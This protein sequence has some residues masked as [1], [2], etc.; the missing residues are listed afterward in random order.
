[1]ALRCF[2]SFHSFIKSDQTKVCGQD[3]SR[4]TTVANFLLPPTIP[5]VYTTLPAPAGTALHSHTSLRP[6]L[7][8]ITAGTPAQ[9]LRLGRPGSDCLDQLRPDPY[10]P[11]RAD[12]ERHGS[13]RARTSRPGP[14]WARQAPALCTPLTALPHSSDS[15]TTTEGLCPVHGS[16]R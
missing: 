8:H 2:D 9:G 7:I 4:R 5:L 15:R 1:M 13:T 3:Q 12:P 14:A 6:R 11:L 10:G 16:A